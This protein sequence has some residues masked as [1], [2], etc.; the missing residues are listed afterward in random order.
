MDQDSAFMSSLMTYLFHKFDIKIKTVAPYNH[1]SFQADHGIK[2]LSCILTKLLTSL[3]QMWTKY[4]SLATFGYSMF[5]TPN[6]GNYSPHEL[7]FGI[8]PKLLLN[9]EPNLDIKVS[10]S[11]RE[12]YELSN[13]RIKYLQDILFNF[14]SRRLA[15]INKDRVNFQYKGGDLVYIISPL[16]SQLRTASQKVAIKYVG[17]VVVYKIIDPHNYLIMTLDGKILRGIFEQE[18]LKPTIIRTNQGNVQHLADL[19]QIMNT[20]LKF[21]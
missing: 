12:Y 10:R 6:V 19:R 15:M 14:K 7:T 9:V 3:G 2:S 1:Q 20:N 11:F 8:K 21:I 18:R 16:T 13:K 5:N 4:L 17:L